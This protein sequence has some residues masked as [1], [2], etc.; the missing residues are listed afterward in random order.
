M[1]KMI[2]LP[3]TERWHM[4][5]GVAFGVV[6]KGIWKKV[7]PANDDNNLAIV[8]RIML[9]ETT[10]RLILVNAGFG[11]KRNEKY[12]SFK[13]ITESA[14]LTHCIENAGYRPDDITDL[15]FTHLHDDHCG[16]ATYFE[17]TLQKTVPVFSKA[18]F[19]ISQKQWKWALNPNAREAASY[20]KDNL[21]PLEES[22]RLNLLETNE[23]PFENEGITLRHYDGHTGGQMI[24]FINVKNKIVIYIS[25]F[26]PSS[27]HIPLP[28][29]ASVDIAPLTALEE[30]EKFLE[31]AVSKEFII[32]FEH[33]A[34]T[35]A[36]R[37]EKTEKGFQAIHQGSF[38]DFF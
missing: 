16:G 32:V 30:K 11:N 21:I 9:I 27:A 35:E 2:S 28:Y 23:Q 20:F 6:P 26:I 5:G 3:V 13:H 12:Y 25:D 7:Y 34:Y 18:K 24:P 19:W 31:E 17:N 22:G 15:I 4:D 29:I 14:P 36:C 37:I 10:N 8:N 33:D 1:V 38:S